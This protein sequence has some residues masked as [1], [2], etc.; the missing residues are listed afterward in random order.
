MKVTIVADS[1]GRYLQEQ[2][3]EVNG[4]Y[5]YSVCVHPGQGLIRS[6][7]SAQFKIRNTNPDIVIIMSGICDITQKDRCTGTISLREGDISSVVSSYLNN[8]GRAQMETLQGR[9]RV[10]FATLTGVD[11]T[12]INNRARR[13][14]NETEYKHYCT[15]NKYEHP[16]QQTLN[17]IIVTLNRTIVAY[18]ESNSIPTTWLAEVVHPHTSGRHRFRYERL[19][20]GCHPTAWTVAR[21][22]TLIKRAVVKMME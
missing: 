2:L 19:A 13:N 15:S 11:L 7:K 22:A 8:M 18:N 5:E 17:M 3:M 21:W 14:M 16:D 4:K 1:R 6:V 12:D 9:Y 20:D 10:S